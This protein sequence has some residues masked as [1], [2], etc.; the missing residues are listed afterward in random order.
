MSQTL[1]PG[2]C[3]KCFHSR[4]YHGVVCSGS[5]TCLCEKF[6]E[7]YLVEFAQKIERVKHQYR[8]LYDR[9][10][11]LLALIPQIRNA[12]EKSFYAVFIWVWYGFKI[13]KGTELNQEIWK[14]LPN[15]DSVNRAKRFVKHDRE[16]LRTYK[17]EV[18]IEQTA[19]YQ[20]ICE[21]AIGK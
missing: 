11:Y 3:S 2:L 1:E 6:I 10:E 13:K 8:S 14:R 16:D 5:I 4:E 12:G 21:L 20:A 17:K 7:S 18:L 15:Q 9:A 19:I